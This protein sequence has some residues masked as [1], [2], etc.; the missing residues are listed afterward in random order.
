MEDRPEAGG[1][2]TFCGWHFKNSNFLAGALTRAKV[3]SWKNEFSSV[4]DATACCEK[5]PEKE[6]ALIF[7]ILRVES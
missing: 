7:Y 6:R 5:A 2:D 4:A 1:T 3:A